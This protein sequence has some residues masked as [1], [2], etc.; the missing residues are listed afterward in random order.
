MQCKGIFFV[1]IIKLISVLVEHLSGFPSFSWLHGYTL[2]VFMQLYSS[3]LPLGQS[4]SQ[5]LSFLFPCVT[6]LCYFQLIKHTTTYAKLLAAFWSDK[7]KHFVNALAFNG[8]K[9]R[10]QCVFRLYS[11]IFSQ[12]LDTTLVQGTLVA[13][14]SLR[15]AA[16][17]FFL[18]FLQSFAFLVKLR[19]LWRKS[20]GNDVRKMLSTAIHNHPSVKLL[21]FSYR[22]FIRSSEGSLL[23]WAVGLEHGNIIIFRDITDHRSTLS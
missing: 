4:Q 6:R 3:L 10:L 9:A 21:W 17:E 22:T 20:L 23:L 14:R 8:R 7:N 2:N 19:M 11:A 15:T 18:S 16:A 5:L 13:Q 12:K 1:T